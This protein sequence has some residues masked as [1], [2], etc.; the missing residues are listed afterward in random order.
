MIGRPK[1]KVGDKVV[2]RFPDFENNAIKDVEG[3]VA[4]VD[5]YGTFFDQSDVSY[6]ILDKKQNMLFKHVKEINVVKKIG[7]IDPE[8]IDL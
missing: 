1:Y 2:F 7:E 5:S 4:I 6:D 3:I 8:T